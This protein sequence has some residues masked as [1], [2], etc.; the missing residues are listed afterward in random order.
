MQCSNYLMRTYC[1][2][3]QLHLCSI[4]SKQPP[5]MLLVRIELLGKT[6]LHC[7]TTRTKWNNVKSLLLVQAQITLNLF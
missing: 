4:I 5:Q 3:K 1:F 2:S 7:V 6:L